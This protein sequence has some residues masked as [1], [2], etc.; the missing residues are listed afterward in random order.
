[1]GM[2]DTPPDSSGRPVAHGGAG[3]SRGDGQHV[4][5]AA[6]WLGGLG[7]V[8][9]VALAIAGHLTGASW[10]WPALF[11][12]CA[13]GA[14]ILSFLG[15]IQWGLAIVGGA[16]ESRRTRRLIWS[17]V[18]SLVAWAALLLP[19]H[20]ALPLLALAFG[21]MLWLDI[22]ASAAEEAPPWYPR[23]RWPLTVTV[24]TSLVVGALA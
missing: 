19:V 20:S 1:M 15:G 14:V 17:I 23:L 6:K 22:R 24:V 7:A 10:Q 3:D 2:S 21:G 12:L 4:P 8:P 18:P 16:H 5:A 13:Y 9:F 11:A